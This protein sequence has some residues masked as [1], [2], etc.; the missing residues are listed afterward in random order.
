MLTQVSGFQKNR[1]FRR[2]EHEI[3]VPSEVSLQETVMT[4]TW[5][6]VCHATSW[7]MTSRPEKP[8]LTWLTNRKLLGSQAPWFGKQ[9]AGLPLSLESDSTS[10]NMK[11]ELHWLNIWKES[12]SLS[13]KWRFDL[14]FDAEDTI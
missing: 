5:S 3:G 2:A 4:G 14:T 11:N 7:P 9:D 13:D 8:L 10:Q 12:N 1:V 6:S